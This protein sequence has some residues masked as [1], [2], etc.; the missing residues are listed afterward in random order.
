MNDDI[1]FLKG[2]QKQIQY[3]DE[4]DY[5]SQAS[6]RFW[7]I[8]DYKWVLTSEDN[9]ERYSVYVPDD[10]EADELES[11]MQHLKEHADL[12]EEAWAEEE[13]IDGPD[14]ALEWINKHVDEEAY[15]IPEEEVHF[16]YP[17]TMFLT[18]EEAKSHIKQ[19][20]YHYTGRVHT[21]AMTAWRAPKVE[22]LLN[23]LKDFDWDSAMKSEKEKR[24][25]V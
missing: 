23:I 3:E 12:S 11:Y 25:E 5:D 13:E 22:R 10:G 4:H 21:Y 6:P 17:D 15:L 2:L 7:T 19:N 18:K 16:V 14:A 1:E 24:K 9:A 20:H 8:G